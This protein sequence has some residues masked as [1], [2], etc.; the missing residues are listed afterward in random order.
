L[1]DY[2]VDTVWATRD[3]KRYGVDLNGYV[4][5]GASPRATIALTM[6]AKAWAFLNGRGYVTPHDGKTFA[7][8]V[9]RHRVAVNYEAE[10]E[11]IPSENVI[12][13]VLET[14]YVHCKSLYIV[15]GDIATPVEKSPGLG[16]HRQRYGGARR[17]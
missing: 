8:D 11:N 14:H 3:P 16:R 17:C 4:R 15:G 5:Y 9:M 7:M 6:A 2:I 13:K 10:A 1:K 12:T